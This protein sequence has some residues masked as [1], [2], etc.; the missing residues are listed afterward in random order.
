MTALIGTENCFEVLFNSFLLLWTEQ[1]S[2]HGV[3]RRDAVMGVK[4]ILYNLWQHLDICIRKN[5]LVR[6]ALALRDTEFQ[7]D[8]LVSNSSRLVYKHV[9]SIAN[10]LMA[11]PMGKVY[12]ASDEP[13]LLI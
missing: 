13:S 6:A 7:T 1:M 11:D 4:E 10:T 5:V 12:W 3:P 8:C 9:L 2:I